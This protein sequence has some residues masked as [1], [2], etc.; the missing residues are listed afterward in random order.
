MTTEIVPMSV[1]ERL[2]ALSAQ[3]EQISNELHQQRQERQ[4]WSELVQDL[5]PI[6][7]QAMTMATR[8]LDADPI[9][10]AEL[11][12]LARALIRD[13]PVL[14]AWLRPLRAMS[15]LADEIGPLATPAVASL[16]A[17]LQ[18]LDERGYFS[19]ARE[20]AGVL[21]QVVGSFSEDD[22]RLLGENIVLIL[23]TVKQMT[24]PEVMTMLRRTALTVQEAQVGG[25][26][27][28]PSTL[29]LLRQLRDPLVRRGFAQMLTT[30][31]ALGTPADSADPKP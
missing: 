26:D 5:E 6:A 1:D 27:E 10:I 30:L 20:A 24:Q 11:A 21:D 28:A 22:V 15:A 14:E 3:L 29:A 9:E 8:H 2:A 16:T 12:S 23:Q 18:Q 4:R 7:G 31:R 13:A 25:S 19:F 17:R